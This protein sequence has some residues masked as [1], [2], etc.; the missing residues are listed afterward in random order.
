MKRQLLLVLSTIFAICLVCSFATACKNN[1]NPIP[2]EEKEVVYSEKTNP[3]A[4]LSWQDY[5][6][7]GT[8]SF[9]DV[10][11]PVLYQFEGSYSEAYQ[12]DYS[13]E[14][15]YINCY[16]DGLL[17][18]TLGGNGIY[19]YWTNRDARD[20]EQFVLHILRHGTAEYNQGVYDMLAEKVEDPDDYYEYSSSFIWNRGIIR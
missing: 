16:R 8:P 3:Y 15:L 13:R 4:S 9:N 17:Y 2:T 6:T 18:G 14:Y 20:R 12:G 11:T 7:I 5:A 10:A 1:V 19:G